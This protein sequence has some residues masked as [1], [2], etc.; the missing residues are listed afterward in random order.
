MLLQWHKIDP[1]NEREIARNNAIFT[2][3]GN[4]NPFIEH[5]EFVSQIWDNILA[6]KTTNSK[7]NTP[8]NK[9]KKIIPKTQKTTSKTPT[10]SSN[11]IATGNLYFATYIEGTGNNKALILTNGS[12]HSI[13]LSDYTVKKQTNGKG[14]WS[15]G[16][17]IKGKLAPKQSLTLLY[18]TS[19]LNCNN[20][21]ILRFNIEELAFNGNDPI[22]LFYNQTL[23]DC[24]GNFNDTSTFSENETLKRKKSNIVP[25]IHFT[26][27]DWEILPI[28]TCQ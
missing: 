25:N 2:R 4:R 24:L 18:S 23:I 6:T 26:K 8:I 19:N 20:S 9:P 16:L 12:P 22:G 15:K 13:N 27:S 1:V 10:P 28:D 17:K 14:N 21:N 3:Q 5:P 7:Q 11:T